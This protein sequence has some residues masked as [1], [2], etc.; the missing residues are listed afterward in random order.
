M[1][2][3]DAVGRGGDFKEQIGS[4]L[5]NGPTFGPRPAYD[6][7]SQAAGAVRLYANFVARNE[8]SSN[9]GQA[10]REYR[11]ELSRVFNRDTDRAQAR[12]AATHPDDTFLEIEGRL[13]PLEGSVGADPSSFPFFFPEIGV[14]AGAGIGITANEESGRY[15]D[16]R[17]GFEGPTWDPEAA[18]CGAGCV[19]AADY[20]VGAS[21]EA[22]GVFNLS[23]IDILFD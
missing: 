23:P 8:V 19:G 18:V 22:G 14:T 7:A 4:R 2:R 5:L 3:G 12:F 9:P 21:A 1:R 10:G 16:S 13:G 20:G 15:L 11:E 17:A 6:D